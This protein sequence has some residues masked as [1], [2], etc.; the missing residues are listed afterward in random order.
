MKALVVYDSQFGN[1]E[2][3]A[4]AIGSGLSSQEQVSVKKVDNITSD[5]LINVDVIIVGCP[6][7]RLSATPLMKQWLDSLPTD[8]LRGIQAAAFDTRFTE[9]KLTELSSVLS[10]FVRVFG[11]AADPIAKRL[12][13]KGAELLAKPEGFYVADTEGPLLEKEI[14]RAKK[15]ALGLQ[16]QSYCVSK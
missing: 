11:Y 16:T 1:T 14:D 3:I 12:K 8:R 7:Q 5:D 4:Q 15:W 6:T 2:K 10:F 13:K 9:E